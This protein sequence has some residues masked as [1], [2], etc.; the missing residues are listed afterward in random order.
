MVYVQLF[1][2]SFITIYQNGTTALMYAS[3]YGNFVIAKILIENNA[4]KNIQDKVFFF[5]FV[6][7]YFYKN[8]I[9]LL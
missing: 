3:E 5:F 7:F 4:D 2:F 9:Y 8:K 1:L 6:F